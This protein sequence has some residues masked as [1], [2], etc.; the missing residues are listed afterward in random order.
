MKRRLIIC[1]DDE[2][3]VLETLER[4]LSQALG[5]NFVIEVAQ[6]PQ[7]AWEIIEDGSDDLELSLVISDWLMPEVRGDKFLVD[8]HAKHPHVNKIMLSGQ[9]DSDA[10]EN[11]QKNANLHAFV[12]KPWDIRKLVQLIAQTS[13]T[14]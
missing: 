14:K 6:G 2:K 7:E 13:Q 9:A 8:L 4:Q 1:V 3:A 11:A 5:E 10:V 12:S